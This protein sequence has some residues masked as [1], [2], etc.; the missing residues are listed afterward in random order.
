MEAVK[1]A[2]TAQEEEKE[3]E[4]EGEGEGE[5][6]EEEEEGSLSDDP[7]RLWCVCKQPHDDRSVPH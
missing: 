2:T 6:S 4:G 3:G 1:A 7:D 5:D